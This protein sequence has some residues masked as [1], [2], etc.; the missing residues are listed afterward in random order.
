MPRCKSMVFDVT[1][2][3]PPIPD[4]PLSHEALLELGFVRV[5][6]SSEPNSYGSYALKQ[7]YFEPPSFAQILTRIRE[8][9]Y[10]R[11]RDDAQRKMRLALGLH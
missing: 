6:R 3:A 11:G 5:T 1:G 4:T 7:S 8:V 2:D 10:A 9:E